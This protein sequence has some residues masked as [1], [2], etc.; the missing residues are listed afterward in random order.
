MVIKSSKTVTRST[1]KTVCPSKTAAASWTL[2]C[3]S[4]GPRS[5]SSANEVCAINKWWKIHASE[6]SVRRGWNCTWRGARVRSIKHSCHL[7]QPVQ[8]QEQQGV[9]LQGSPGFSHLRTHKADC[10]C[11]PAGDCVAS[12]Q[13][14]FLGIYSGRAAAGLGLWGFFL[15]LWMCSVWCVW[16]ADNLQECF[17]VT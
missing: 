10:F 2:F 7:L 9:T 1:W 3:F 13:G 15:R 4:S 12:V 5:I 17:G 16:E 8:E 14:H 11:L 6:W